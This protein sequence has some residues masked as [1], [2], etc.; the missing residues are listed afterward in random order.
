MIDQSNRAGK[1]AVHSVFS[2]KRETDYVSEE[3]NQRQL[4]EEI[5]LLAV[6]VLFFLFLSQ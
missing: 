2:Q 3:P 6:T 5:A 1:A 4:R